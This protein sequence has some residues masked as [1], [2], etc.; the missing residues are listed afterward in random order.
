MSDRKYKRLTFL[1]QTI[2]SFNLYSKC[3]FGK[4]CKKYHVNNEL[5]ETNISEAL[6]HTSLFDTT[7]LKWFD[8]ENI[9]LNTGSRHFIDTCEGGRMLHFA[10]INGYSL[11]IAFKQSN[12]IDNGC[13]K[14][15]MNGTK[16]EDSKNNDTKQIIIT[17]LQNMGYFDGYSS[18]ATIECNSV[19]GVVKCLNDFYIKDTLINK[20]NKKWIDK[21]NNY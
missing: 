14:Y 16:I 10:N 7:F 3:K 5:T 4:Y 15:N 19:R 8:G 20:I 2:C 18:V 1:K 13:I 21:I 17:V 6:G 9:E 11:R 12:S